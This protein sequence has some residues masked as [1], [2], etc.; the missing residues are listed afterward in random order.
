MRVLLRSSSS[1][2]Q[3]L[4]CLFLP[5]ILMSFA[6]ISIS[7]TLAPLPSFAQDSSSPSTLRV[8]SQLVVLDVVVTDAQGSVVTNLDR[9]DFSIYQNGAAQDIRNFDAPEKTSSIPEKAP[10][11]KY[12]RDDWGNAPLTMFVIDAMNTPFEETAYSREEID[13]YLKAQPALLKQP[14]IILWLNDAGFHPVTALSRDRDALISAIDSHKASLTGKLNRGAVV[15]QLSASLSALQQM[16]LFS[17]GNKGS[18]QIIWVGR[19][20]PG[21]NGTLLNGTQLDLLKKAVGSTLD[22]LMASRTSV[23]VIDPTINTK[24]LPEDPVS[25]IVNPNVITQFASDDPFATSFSFMEFVKQTGGKYFYGRNDLNNEIE[26]SITRATNSYTLSY[27]PSDTIQDDKYR[28]IDIRLRDPKLVVQ[29]KQ[30]Y[31]PASQPTNILSAKDLQFGLHEAIV[32]GMVYNGVGLRLEHCQLD[33]NRIS[34]SCNAI[35]DNGS[36]TSVSGSGDSQRTS[37]VAVISALDSKSVL[38][39]NKVY[40]FGLNIPDQPAQNSFTNIPLHITIPP[41]AKIVRVA[42]RDIS[43]R[44]GTADLDPSLVKGLIAT[45]PVAKKIR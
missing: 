4:A 27:V 25:N 14:A 40:K 16:A 21:V 10:K 33:A 30:G 15:E 22:L 7:L 34:T 44:I 17:R 26:S 39:A 35:V 13:R 19:S 24:P 23:Y 1:Y 12:G 45:D 36:L 37:I 8:Q 38:V 3:S 31:Y 11:D 28:K 5:S 41:N 43:G 2:R 42:I 9:S 6:G 20:F 29:A 32:S 18:K